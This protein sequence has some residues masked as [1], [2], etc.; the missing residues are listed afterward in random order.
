MHTTKTFNKTAPV[1]EGSI[2]RLFG[3]NSAGYLISIE[4]QD[5]ANTVVYTFQESVGGTTWTDITFDVDGEDQTDFAL[6]AGNS[7]TLKVKSTQPYVRM[8]AYGDAAV[9]VSIS[10]FKPSNT[11]TTEVQIFEAA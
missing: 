6:L 7:H 1:V 11:G 9:S 4:N 2:F 5:S 10:Y 3:I 8:T